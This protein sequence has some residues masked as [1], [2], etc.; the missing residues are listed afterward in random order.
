MNEEITNESK[1][2]RT[3]HVYS[4]GFCHDPAGILG[5]K[6]SLLSLRNAIDKAIETEG[7]SSCLQ[8]TKDGEGYSF[9]V[10][11]RELNENDGL[12]YS[13]DCCMKP[14][15]TGVPITFATKEEYKKHV[16]EPEL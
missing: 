15:E 2:K 8:F 3:L 16:R 14:I 10:S 6:E 4:Q 7:V 9:L 11:C 5:T 13:L 1:F 12:P